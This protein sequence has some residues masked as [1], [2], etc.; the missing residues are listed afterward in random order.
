MD[1]Q[2]VRE[3]PTDYAVKW[4]SDN[5]SPDKLTNDLMSVG[6]GMFPEVAKSVSGN[7]LTE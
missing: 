6:L 3:V 4:V 1:D 7:T 2:K 5:L